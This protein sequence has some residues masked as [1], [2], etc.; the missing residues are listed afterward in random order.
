MVPLRPA[1]NSS[2]RFLRLPR[3]KMASSLSSV[4]LTR[5]ATPTVKPPTPPLSSSLPQLQRGVASLSLVRAVSGF[6]GV[7]AVSVGEDDDGCGTDADRTADAITNERD[8]FSPTRITSYV[9]QEAI[10]KA[11]ELL[12]SVDLST[13]PLD[14]LAP[15]LT[16]LSELRTFP[17]AKAV[18]KA[19][20]GRGIDTLEMY[21]QVLE[22]VRR[23]LLPREIRT[24]FGDSQ[25]AMHNAFPGEEERGGK[26]GFF[27]ENVRT[28]LSSEHF[29]EVQEVMDWLKEEGLCL[30]NEFYD[31]LAMHLNYMKQ[32][33]ILLNI[34]MKL[35]RNGQQPTAFF[36]N[37]TLDCLMRC[38]MSER[39]R[40]L[41]ERMQA[42][43]M[44]T[45][46]TH[47]AWMN[48]LTELGK[49][50]KDV[51]H[52]LRTRFPK[53][54]PI[55]FNVYLKACLRDGRNT[56]ALA[57]LQEMI[58]DSAATVVTGKI[59]VNHLILAPQ[60]MQHFGEHLK[61][62][63]NFGFPV[64]ANDY[65]SLIRMWARIDPSQV[66]SLWRQCPLPN[67]ASLYNA[68]LSV[69]VDRR[70]PGEWKVVLIND[71]LGSTDFQVR[72]GSLAELCK[73]HLPAGI[74]S[75]L[76]AMQDRS[77]PYT[78][79]TIEIL[80]RR[81][82][83]SGNYDL[84]LRL[85]R[86]TQGSQDSQVLGHRFIPVQPSHRNFYLTALMNTG[87]MEEAGRELRWMNS[88]RLPVA[89]RNQEIAKQN[90]LYAQESHSSRGG[91][92]PRI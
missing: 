35:E 5:P 24:L 90:G 88:R 34:A 89:A 70:V 31:G 25:R 9:S 18:L 50:V 13:A 36:Y 76:A 39:A 54:S 7:G 72:P 4:R 1:A 60:E 51:W 61:Q 29:Q 19:A 64:H 15:L 20:R 30:P 84:I 17:Q 42:T 77:V 45:M 92:N 75:V 23:S 38:G 74:V 91:E 11:N 59:L 43:G 81:L 12:A 27:L 32:A 2:F 63:R 14:Q 47:V 40:M 53:P 56:E 49:P 87:A 86:E 68:L 85:Y 82:L 71:C 67:S 37:R 8:A 66:A 28:P 80:M 48:A 83:V 65:A 79:Q 62:L 73:E 21:V 57:I 44:D 78:S 58:A 16:Q 22:A 33:G 6:G 3:R 69:L 46:E 41:Y 10:D 55:A 26:M 52:L